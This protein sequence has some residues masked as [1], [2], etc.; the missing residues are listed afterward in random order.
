MT[1]VVP[2]EV[3]DDAGLQRRD[4]G[5]VDKPLLVVTPMVIP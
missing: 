4:S 1:H 3:R 5:F 2:V